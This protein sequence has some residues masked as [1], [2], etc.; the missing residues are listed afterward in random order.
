[1]FENHM[2]NHIEIQI[3]KVCFDFCDLKKSLKE[4]FQGLFTFLDFTEAFD[5][6]QSFR[7]A[8]R[9]VSLYTRRGGI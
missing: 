5:V 2:Q 4:D 7:H 9:V 3:G 6:E 8:L 1:M